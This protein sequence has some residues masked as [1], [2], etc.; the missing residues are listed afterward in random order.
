MATRRRSVSLLQ[1][2]CKD[3]TERNLPEYLRLDLQTLFSGQLFGQQMRPSKDWRNV[4]KNRFAIMLSASN[5]F[6]ERRNRS[7]FNHMLSNEIIW[8]CMVSHLPYRF[9]RKSVRRVTKPSKY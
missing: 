9:V 3:F 4:V 2:A 1:D 6:D 5:E 8:D 7:C